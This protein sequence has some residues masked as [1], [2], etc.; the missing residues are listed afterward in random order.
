MKELVIVGMDDLAEIAGFY[1]EHDSEYK[2]A[3]FA[4]DRK[5]R[6]T[7]EFCGLPAYD[8]ED[9]ERYYPPE[10]YEMFIAIGYSHLNQAREDKYHA[11]KRKGYRLAS[12]ISTY[13]TCW[14][15]REQMGDNCFIL[16][17]NTIQP[18]VKIGN[19]V[20][21]WSGNHIGHHAQIADHVFITSHVVLSGRTCV[22]NNCFIGINA[23]VHDH[24]TIG[25]HCVVGSGALITRDT[26]PGS[27]YKGQYSSR[28]ER[29]SG[30]LRYFGGNTG[31]SNEED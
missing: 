12:Y 8:F 6:K 21:M 18:F 19:N 2:V 1:F 13:A 5:Y 10:K 17:D 15:G 29:K 14:T 30:E 20:T 11:A 28:Y 16:E 7:D 31:N 22:R 24:V 4:A 25:D 26:E 3:A 27:V 9:I 23:S